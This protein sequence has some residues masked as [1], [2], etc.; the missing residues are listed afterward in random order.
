MKNRLR[1]LALLLCASMLAFSLSACGGSSDAD[2]ADDAAQA[3]EEAAEE[4]VEAAEDEAAESVEA[5]EE[6]AAGDDA[7]VTGKFASIQEFVESDIMQSQLESQMSSL[8]GTGMTMELSGEDNKL[9]YTFI[10][11]DEALS[12]AMD[13]ATLESTLD[14]QASTFESVAGTLPAAIEVENPVVVVRYVGSDGTELVSREFA[15]E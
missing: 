13:T 12:A 5:A 9:I 1:K 7:A 3:E 11:E 10:I 15:A 14:S 4:E 2:N 6:D 8:E